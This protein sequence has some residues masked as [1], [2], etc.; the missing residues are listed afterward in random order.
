MCF[1]TFCIKLEW[2][3]YT[4]KK[5]LLWWAY[6]FPLTLITGRGEG[7]HLI[8]T[9]WTLLKI[10]ILCHIWFLVEMLS[11]YKLI[12]SCKTRESFG[13]KEKNAFIYL[14]LVR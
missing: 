9:N 14:L 7:K 12:R 11:K 3:T 13:L 6:V 1:D 2:V 5:Y 8:Q 10:M 4:S